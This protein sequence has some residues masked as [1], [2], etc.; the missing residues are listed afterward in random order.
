[1]IFV[2]IFNRFRWAFCQLE[3]LRHCL[4]P[5]VHRTLDELPESLD[6]TYERVL[7]EIKK[8]NRDHARR[9]L[10]CLVVAVQPLGV[11]ELAEV[12][13]SGFGDTEGI[14]K[15]KLNWRWEDQEQALLASCSSL[16]ALV[17]TGGS[18]AVQFSHFSVKEYLTSTRL[19]I[20]SGAVSGYHVDL[21]PAHA[22]LAQACMGVLLQA[23]DHAEQN[24]VEKSSPLAE[25]AAEHRVT[26][27][28]FQ[29]VSL[30]LRKAMEYLFDP[31]GPYFVAWLQLHDLDDKHRAALSTLYWNITSKSGATPLYYVA[32]CGFQDLVE[33]LISKYPQHVD[34]RGGYFVT[35]LVAALAR[36]HFE[37]AELLRHNGADV[38]VC[39]GDAATPLHAASC[40]GGF[41]MVQT[42]LNYKVDVDPRDKYGW[43]PMHAV[44]QG[45][46][47][48]P[49]IYQSFPDVA[50]LLLEHCADV[51]ARTSRGVDPGQTPLHI[52]PCNDS[53]MPR[54][55]MTEVVHV[56]LKHG[57]NVA[58][59]DDQGRTPLN[60]VAESGDVDIARVLLEHGA[61][62]SAEDNQGRT[63]FQIALARG[64]NDTI[65]L[66]SDH[67]AR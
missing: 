9:V 51:N 40:R 42:L 4:P 11:E 44:S 56:L 47:L 53:I 37:T 7:R 59:E 1:M 57:A 63:P 18:R 3:T 29:N 36:R 15:L 65:K 34:V 60:V 5:G 35:P 23:Y 27:A 30:L 14:P 67:G 21:E 6:E 49:N 17:D 24:D 32:L 28:R 2:E 38:N 26:H 48:I 58:A 31:D 61:N 54:Y 33:C 50:R 66:L 41:E 16:I 13:A 52:L 19:A 20:S 43:T 64:D 25:Y 55:N 10:Q 8:P 39:Y 22:T 45:F 46:H 62:V 12:L